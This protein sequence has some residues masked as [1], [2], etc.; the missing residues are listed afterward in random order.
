MLLSLVDY[1][2]TVAITALTKLLEDSNASSSHKAVL[3]STIL[4]FRSLGDRCASFLPQ[5][6]GPILYVVEQ[7]ALS[8]KVKDQ[9]VGYIEELGTLMDI[10]GEWLAPFLDAIFHL[11]AGL[12]DSDL[13]E[14]VLRVLLSL[15]S[16]LDPSK[17]HLPLAI[18]LKPLLALLSKDPDPDRT[19]GIEADLALKVLA[20]FRSALNGYLH[21]VLPSIVALIDRTTFSSGV[22]LRVRMAAMDALNQIIRACDVGDFATLLL[23]PL[24]HALEDLTTDSLQYSGAPRKVSTAGGAGGSVETAIDAPPVHKKERIDQRILRKV[25]SLL[26]S[27]VYKLEEEFVMFAPMIDEVS[28]YGEGNEKNGFGFG[29]EVAQVKALAVVANMGIYWKIF[30]TG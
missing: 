7:N 24:V 30:L 17:V 9:R 18:V 29:G 5:I 16:R 1:Y 27:L 11:V 25:V 22:P 2:P 20:S 14:Q 19:A 21:L 3:D 10:V 4:I 23:H 15:V 28:V 8:N 12:W 6:L 26:T 13:L